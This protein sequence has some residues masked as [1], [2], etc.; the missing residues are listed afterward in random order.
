MK[1]V[2]PPMRERKNF[3][4]IGV[5]EIDVHDMTWMRAKSYID[6]QLT[7]AKKDVY[8]LR[9]VHGYRGGTKIKEMIRK[10]YRNHEKVIRIEYGLNQGITDLVLK[11]LF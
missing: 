7:K 11:D 10:Q 2:S 4:N 1:A 3:M 9:V 6:S 5:L 8:R